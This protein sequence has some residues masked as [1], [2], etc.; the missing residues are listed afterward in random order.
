MNEKITEQD[1]IKAQEL[2]REVVVILSDVSDVEQRLASIKERA[3]KLY[4]H[5]DNI[6]DGENQR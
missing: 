5:L 3:T 2:L 1:M 6:A 4:E